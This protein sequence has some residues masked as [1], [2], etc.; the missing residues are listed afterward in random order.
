MQ[1]TLMQFSILFFNIFSQSVM[2]SFV[3]CLLIILSVSVRVWGGQREG[4][5]SDGDRR[6][7][8]H[9]QHRGRHQLWICG[10]HLHWFIRFFL[11]T[12]IDS[13]THTY[14]QKVVYTGAL[15]FTVEYL[16]F[17]CD[18]NFTMCPAVC[19]TFPAS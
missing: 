19:K 10:T 4:S 13:I 5:G 12:E 2:D 7:R 15:N 3:N 14:L 6:K 11:L 18:I 1:C 9:P 16:S 8:G 17:K